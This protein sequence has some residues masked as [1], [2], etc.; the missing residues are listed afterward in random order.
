MK[1]TDAPHIDEFATPK[2]LIRICPNL[3]LTEQQMNWALRH[4]KTNGL[5]SAVKKMGRNLVI[6]IPT[7]TRWL[8]DGGNLKAS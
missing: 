2:A 6:H 7:F 3:E 4:R 8:L 1:Q 5:D